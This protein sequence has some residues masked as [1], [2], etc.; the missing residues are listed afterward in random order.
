VPP[1]N[2]TIPGTVQRIKIGNIKEN[3]KSAHNVHLQFINLN[4]NIKNNVNLNQNLWSQE[5]IKNIIT[6]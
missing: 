4:F 5:K 1:D 3:K 2:H 6:L